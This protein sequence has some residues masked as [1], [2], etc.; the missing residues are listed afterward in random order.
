MF[1]LNRIKNKKLILKHL[2]SN[3]ELNPQKLFLIDG[4]GAIL[5]AFLVGVVLTKF[6]RIF[7][8]PPETLYFLAVI[9]LFFA[10]YDLY[11]YQSK[12]QKIGLL[13]K[14]IATLNLIYCLISIGLIIHHFDTITVLGW[15]YI[16]IEIII[17]LILA[18]IEFKV[19][20]KINKAST[21]NVVCH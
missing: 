16:L 1:V 5:S 20:I 11:G 10:L 13:L 17:V 2:I 4:V 8:I 9:P 3:V 15:I 19:G 12:N 6:E 21:Q 18:I 14:G 7:G